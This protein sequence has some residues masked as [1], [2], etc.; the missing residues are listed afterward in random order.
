MSYIYDLE[1]EAGLSE[2]NR[3]ECVCAFAGTC[4]RVRACLFLWAGS[5]SVITG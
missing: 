5:V 4:A 1:T 3:K 2:E